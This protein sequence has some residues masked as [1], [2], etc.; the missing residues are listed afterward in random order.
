MSWTPVPVPQT[1]PYFSYGKQILILMI[2]NI[3]LRPDYIPK[4]L[5]LKGTIGLENWKISLRPQIS[6][7]A[8]HGFFASHLQGAQLDCL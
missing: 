7:L 8:K 5:C 3:F 1:F 2:L 6:S 4:L